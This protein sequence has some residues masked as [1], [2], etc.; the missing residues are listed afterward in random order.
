MEAMMGAFPTSDMPGHKRLHDRVF[1][2][3]DCCQE[4]Q[5]IDFKESAFWDV[6]KW[7]LIKT[8]LAMGNLRDGGIIIIGVSERGGTWEL[9]G[10]KPEHLATYD[11]DVLIS[12]INAYSS[13]HIDI[14]IVLVEYRNGNK[15]LSFQVNEFSDT[16]I[17]CKKNGDGGLIE[18]G[19]YVRPPGM[20]RTTRVMNAM[21]MHDLLELAAEKRA[22]HILEASRRVGLVPSDTF[23]KRF[24]D[25]LEGL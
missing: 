20:A 22:R 21:Q 9:T 14:D 7:R 12:T 17:I 3:L 15:F 2:A 8:A 11:V 25:E 24:E 1:N 4:S 5:G 18:G 10:I 16:P 19:I 6:L 23:S 13:P